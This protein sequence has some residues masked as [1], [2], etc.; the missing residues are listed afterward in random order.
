MTIETHHHLFFAMTMSSHILIV[1]PRTHTL[2]HHLKPSRI[3]SQ[4]FPLPLSP[5]TSI[6]LLHWS[7]HPGLGGPKTGPVFADQRHHQQQQPL[8]G[9]TKNPAE[10][11]EPFK[12]HPSRLLLIQHGPVWVWEISLATTAARQ[13]LLLLLQTDAP[14]PPPLQPILLK[15]HQQGLVQQQPLLA[16][17]YLNATTLY[18]N[19]AKT[20]WKLVLF[21]QPKNK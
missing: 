20:V 13:S 3:L 15:Q 10:L 21:L 16:V 18:R 11:W 5:F 2:L 7:A 6:F 19:L 12:A 17:W 1:R 14:P 8:P 9:C 4:C